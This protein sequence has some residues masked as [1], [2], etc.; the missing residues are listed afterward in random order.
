[1][2]I[3]L[4]KSDFDLFSDIMIIFDQ[5]GHMEFTYLAIKWDEIDLLD[6]L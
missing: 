1:M 6:I 3:I 4:S 2:N 5:L